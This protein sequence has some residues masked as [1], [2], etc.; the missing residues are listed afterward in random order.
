[1]VYE[2]GIPASVSSPAPVLILLISLATLLIGSLMLIDAFWQSSD[3]ET[4]V[5]APTPPPP[6]AERQQARGQALNP[7]SRQVELGS[8]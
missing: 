1:M 7:F 6:Q 3:P 8:C 2:R 5:T 4:V